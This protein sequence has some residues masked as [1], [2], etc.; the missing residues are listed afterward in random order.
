LNKVIPKFLGKNKCGLNVVE[1]YANV[2][3]NEFV[4]DGDEF[5]IVARMA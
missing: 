3:G 1:Q 5:A 4:P 2:A